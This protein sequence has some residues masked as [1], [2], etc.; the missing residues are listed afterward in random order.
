MILRTISVLLVASAML[1]GT[2]HAVSQRQTDAGKKACVQ[3]ARRLCPA[4]MKSL[5]RK[6]VEACMIAK[7]DQT[8]TICHAAMLRIKA[9]REASPKR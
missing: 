8:S 6:K 7:I 3:E 4:E 9:Q 2:A 1:A 5:S